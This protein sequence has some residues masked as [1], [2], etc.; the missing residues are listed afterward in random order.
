MGALKATPNQATKTKT[1]LVCLVI[2]TAISL[3]IAAPPKVR[4]FR[5]ADETATIRIFAPDRLELITKEGPGI[6]SYSHQGAFL[7]VVV[8]RLGRVDVL[9]FRKVPIGLI[10]PDGTVL[11]DEEHFH[12][13]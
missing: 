7:R 11:Y 10:A 13:R 2:W 4:L 1:L 6:H 8:T 3:S 5:S 12:R 9:N